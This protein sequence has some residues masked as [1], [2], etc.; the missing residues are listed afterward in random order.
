MEQKHYYT[1]LT[2][3]LVLESSSKHGAN[4]LTPP[5]KEPLLKQFLEKFGAP[6]II[7]L[8]IAGE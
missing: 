7:I 4:I 6:L 8:L 3:A 1:G 5:E 2:E